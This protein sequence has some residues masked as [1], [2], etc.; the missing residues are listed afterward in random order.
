[1]LSSSW[2]TGFII[3]NK[4]SLT[5]LDPARPLIKPGVTNRLDSG[6]AKSV[7]VMHTNAGYYGEG[8]KIGHVDFCVN[9]GRKQPYCETTNSKAA[10][11]FRI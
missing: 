3:A 6:D 5:G 4:K 2:V 1:M 7:Q 8:G 10:I 11:F 9:G